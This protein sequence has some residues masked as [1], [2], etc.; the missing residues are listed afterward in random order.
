MSVATVTACIF[1]A[2]LLAS[3]QSLQ[4]AESCYL[5]GK[6]LFMLMTVRAASPD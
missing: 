1:S 6:E 3:S 2:Q 5:F 4:K